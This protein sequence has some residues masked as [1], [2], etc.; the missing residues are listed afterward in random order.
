MVE[1]SD[2]VEVGGQ[3]LYLYCRIA[4]WFNTSDFGKGTF[5]NF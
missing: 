5:Q 1:E 2:E 4:V 3:D